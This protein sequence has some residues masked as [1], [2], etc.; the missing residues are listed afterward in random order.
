MSSM[1]NRTYDSSSRQAQATQTRDR[2]LET[3]NALFQ[4]LGF[5]GVKIDTIAKEAG[6]STPTVYAQ[7][8]SKRGILKALL[9][10]SLPPEQFDA[11]VQQARNAGSSK[12]HLQITAK[13]SRQ[14]YDAEKAKIEFYQGSS[15][16]SPE[17]KEVEQEMERRRYQRL[18]ET[19]NTIA[20]AGSLLE[21]LDATKAR[22][23]LWSF[24][25]RD[26]YRM[27]VIE[28]SWPSDF[29]EDWLA[30]LLAKVILKPAL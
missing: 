23:I 10:Q 21:G 22:D 9:D 6:V 30:K 7:F 14:L 20:K 29:Y 3:A 15:M 8:Q 5:E 1:K 26:L 4:S 18:E 12:E 2:I 13:I 11:L 17:L 25:G 24:T 16:I 19:I 28:Q 27:L